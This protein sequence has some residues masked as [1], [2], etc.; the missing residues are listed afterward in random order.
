MSFDKWAFEYV[1]I[2]A[3]TSWYRDKERFVWITRVALEMWPCYW[4]TKLIHRF[5]EKGIII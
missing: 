1:F 4:F 5:K 2:C 3:M